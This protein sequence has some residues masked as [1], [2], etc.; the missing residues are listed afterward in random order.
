MF[1]FSEHQFLVNKTME[2]DISLLREAIKA[3]EREEVK[4]TYYRY[5]DTEKYVVQIK[6]AC[7]ITQICP[8]ISQHNEGIIRQQI[9]EVALGEDLPVLL[10]TPYIP[11]AIA[12]TFAKEG[13]NYIDKAGNSYIHHARL[14][15]FIAGKKRETPIKT[16]KSRIFGEAG[17]KLLY[18]LLLH[19]EHVNRSF[20]EL[21][22]LTHLSL[23]SVSTI[24]QEL[25]QK[26][27]V[28]KGEER[29]LMEKETLLKR[30][31]IAY[32][33]VLRPKL[34][35]KRM[36]PLS[37]SFYKEWSTLDLSIISIQTQWGGEPAGCILTKNLTPATY[38]IYTDT[39]WQNIGKTLGLIPDE[40]GRIEILSHFSTEEPR[41]T[42]SPL[43][44]YTD[45]MISDDSRNREVA[46][47]IENNE[48]SYLK[49]RTE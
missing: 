20:R 32:S 23:G 39:P 5:K 44:V 17:T 25:T 36:R 18:E 12:K 8:E 9:R 14:L 6:E 43:L 31:L 37:S 16:N 29:I 28:S 35:V 48:L 4:V 15:I 27:F 10:V 30:W 24:F 40:E 46:K 21:A 38:T 7:F 47:I 19:P 22:S 34:L 26:G 49:Q 33:E 3:L 2:Q 1:I 42:V 45:L 11:P 41:N 13:V